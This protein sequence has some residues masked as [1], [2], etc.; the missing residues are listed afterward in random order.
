MSDA[1]HAFCVDE[2]AA[3][4]MGLHGV[5]LRR[6]CEE[7]RCHFEG[8]SVAAR[9]LHMDGRIDGSMKKKLMQL[10]TAV[11]LVRHVSA[12]S[13]G[14][15]VEKLE[16]QLN[17][18]FEP[19][20]SLIER[21]EV[22]RAGQAR[23]AV[24]PQVQ[25]AVQAEVQEVLA[26]G[27]EKVEVDFKDFAKVVDDRHE[28]VLAKVEKESA[29]LQAMGDGFMD[30][31]AKLD[32]AEEANARRADERVARLLSDLGRE[33]NARRADVA[34]LKDLISAEQ[35]VREVADRTIDDALVSAITG[36]RAERQ[37]AD[38]LEAD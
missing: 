1:M 38:A 28:S 4:L 10:D 6:L 17:R 11:S 23:E 12:P 22:V 36:E 2:A 18:N 3:L 19:D 29:K 5:V 7:A 31:M 21:Q 24:Q 26:K 37:A 8:L 20:S 33:T 25:S 30:V 14:A 32:K 15:F 13:C 9:R 27:I 34:S 16:L 35:A